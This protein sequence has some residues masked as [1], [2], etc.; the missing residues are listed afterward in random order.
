MEGGGPVVVLRGTRTAIGGSCRRG[1]GGRPRHRGKGP[2]NPHRRPPPRPR[3]PPSRRAQ[4]GG[5][6]R[7]GG[8]DRG[9]RRGRRWAKRGRGDLGIVAPGVAP[10]GGRAERPNPPPPARPRPSH[11]GTRRRDAK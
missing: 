6:G 8:G 11:R 4:R 7:R 2:R 9:G 1:G 10:R 3:P 5:G